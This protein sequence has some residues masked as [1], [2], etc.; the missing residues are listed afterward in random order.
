MRA[1]TSVTGV[2][3]IAIGVPTPLQA[4]QEQATEERKIEA[5]IKHIQ[6]LRDATFV[7]NGQEYDAATAATFLRRKWAANKSGIK[8]ADQFIDKVA[9]ASSTSGKPYLIRFKDGREMKSGEYLLEELKK[10]E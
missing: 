8:T 3:L 5:L 1:L 9:S 10:L 6:Q 2:F 4:R 7:R